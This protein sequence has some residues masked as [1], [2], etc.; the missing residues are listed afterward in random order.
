MSIQQ[1]YVPESCHLS[2]EDVPW[3]DYSA[4]YPENMMRT[5][6]AKRLIG[7]GG[8]IPHDEVVFGIL[9]LDPGAS[10][11][12]HRH[13]APEIYYV[14]QGRAECRFGDETFVARPGS[15]IQTAPG[16]SHS[17]HSLG[18]EKFVAVAFWWAPGG[19]RSALMCDL[20][21]LDLPE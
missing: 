16:Q 19:N 8:A 3:G 9:E 7:P 21:L 4:H 18:D 1:S 13:E 10:Y 17:F 2:A 14:V 12:S 6:R 11:P 20:E 15:M 5:M